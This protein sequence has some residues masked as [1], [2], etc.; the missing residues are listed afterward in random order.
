[1]HDTT[2]LAPGAVRWSSVTDRP[3]GRRCPNCGSGDLFDLRLRRTQGQERR[4]AYCAGLYDRNRRR[5]VSRSCGYS[6]GEPASRPS[7]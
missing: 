5:I 2:P 6:E 3:P 1:M 4:A 7:V